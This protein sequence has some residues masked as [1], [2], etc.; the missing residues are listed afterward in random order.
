MPK[1]SKHMYTKINIFPCSV[2]ALRVVSNQL[3]C[4]SIHK[5]NV[6]SRYTH[7]HSIPHLKATPLIFVQLYNRAIHVAQ[8]LRQSH[9]LFLSRPFSIPTSQGS[10]VNRHCL[11]HRRTL[12]MLTAL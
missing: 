8:L 10:I 2:L 4:G 3:H 11:S 1:F 9:L 6:V 5:D 7:A 12:S